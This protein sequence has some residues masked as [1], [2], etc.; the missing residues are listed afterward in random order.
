MGRHQLS[1]YWKVCLTNGVVFLLGSLALAFSPMRVSEQVLLSEAVVLA[2]GLGA[3]FALNALLLRLSLAPVDKVIR[4][5][6]AIRMPEPGHRLDVPASRSGARLVRSYNAMLGRLESERSTSNANALAAQEAERHRIAQEL[7]DEIGQNLT[8]VLLGLKQLESR[9]PDDLTDE[10][11]LIRESAR[12][13]LDDVRRVARRLRPG[14]LEDLGLHS[15]LAALCT[16]LTTVGPLQVRRIFGRGLP[17]LN[18]QTELVI[19]RIAQ[20]ALTNVAR[21]AQANNVTLSLTKI[22]DNAVLEVTDDGRGGAEI[23]PGSGIGGMRERALLIGADLMITSAPRQ[24]TEIRLTV[25]LASATTPDPALSIQ[26]DDVSA[27]A[28]GHQED[29]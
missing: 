2:V 12:T 3:M 11:S 6:D 29:S 23:V 17:Q 4:Q 20:E 25:P 19:Y 15:A 10:L 21:H 16:D 27:A 5:M 24:G 8:V 1:L 18:H 22:G 9:I 7:H 13:G 26:T 14:V 28:A